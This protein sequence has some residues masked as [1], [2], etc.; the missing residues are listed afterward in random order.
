MVDGIILVGVIDRELRAWDSRAEGSAA[1][2][3]GTASG[4]AT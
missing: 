2:V 1:I 3:C 4:S